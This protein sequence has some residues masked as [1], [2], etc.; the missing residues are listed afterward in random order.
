MY[1]QRNHVIYVYSGVND[2]KM[3]KVSKFTS[4]PF[5]FLK[6]TFIS[7]TNMFYSRKKNSLLPV[8]LKPYKDGNTA[9]I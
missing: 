8:S 4:W 7:I 3:K 1:I 9:S 2:A 5:H 6:D